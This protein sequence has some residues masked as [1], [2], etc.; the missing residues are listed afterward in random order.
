MRGNA[1]EP[2][3]LDPHR[4]TGTWENNIIGDMLLGLYTEAADATPILGAADKAETSADG[5]R[6][7]FHIRPHTWSDGKPVVAGDFVFAMRR[8]LDPKF[9]AEYC[10]ILFPIKNAVK[11][12]KGELPVD[13]LG[14]SAPDA[15]DADHRP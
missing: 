14:V 8:I 13:Q 4:A 2:K 10:E 5:L 11:V 15:E 1:G 3:S 9:A 6:W 12:N 7:T